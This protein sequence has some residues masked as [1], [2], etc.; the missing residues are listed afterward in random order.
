M[1]VATTLAL[2]PVGTKEIEA[3]LFAPFG[4][5]LLAKE[6]F[7]CF[8]VGLGSQVRGPVRTVL[9]DAHLYGRLLSAIMELVS[10]PSWSST[11]SWPRSAVGSH[12]IERQVAARSVRQ[13]SC[14]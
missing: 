3:H 6:A 13:R 11:R 9:D 12:K 5:G 4:G 10:R 14:L 2:A 7:F 8:T 1:L